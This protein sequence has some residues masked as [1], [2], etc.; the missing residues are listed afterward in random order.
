MKR[1]EWILGEETVDKLYKYKNLGVLKNYI[2]SFLSNIDDN[3]EKTC[4]KGGLTVIAGTT[5]SE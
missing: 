5:C 3:I 2:G 4:S 1:R